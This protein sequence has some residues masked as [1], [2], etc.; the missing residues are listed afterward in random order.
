M[1]PY[2]SALSA[3]S[4]GDLEASFTIRRE[5]GFSQVVPASSF[6]NDTDFNELERKAMKLCRGSVLDV[7]AGAGRHSLELGRMGYTVCSVDISEECTR[8]QKERGIEPALTADVL[9]WNEM[10]FDTVLMLMNGIG[11][12]QDLQGLHQFLKHARKLV[13]EDGQIICDS[14]DVSKSTDPVHIAYR[15]EKEKSGAYRGQQNFTMERA[16]LCEEFK[17]LHIDYA[18]LAE[19]AEENGWSPSLE[20]EQANGHYLATLKEKR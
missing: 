1:D 17:W 12:V 13:N 9:T 11:I 7:G 2:A 5:D 15:N 18:T 8:I 20:C 3:Y 19:I 10:R 6:W 16:S 14:I 4:Q